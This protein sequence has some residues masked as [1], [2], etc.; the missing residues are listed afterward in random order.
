MSTE[1]G[2]RHS[3]VD[4]GDAYLVSRFRQ[5]YIITFPGD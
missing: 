2:Y 1:A 4:D 5:R 3:V